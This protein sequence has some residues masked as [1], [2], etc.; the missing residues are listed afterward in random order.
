MMQLQDSCEHVSMRVYHC[1][2][3]LIQPAWHS[4][5]M[6]ASWVSGGK[7]VSVTRCLHHTKQSC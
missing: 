7:M 1:C 4:C 5:L 3:S 2:L 6:T